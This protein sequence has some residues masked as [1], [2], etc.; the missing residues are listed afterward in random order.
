MAKDGPSAGVTTTT[1]LAS[2][3][4]VPASVLS[5]LDVH[6]LSDVRDVLEPAY[7]QV[8]AA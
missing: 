1:A 4:D 5:E 8:L 7:E 3:D 6:P 2:L